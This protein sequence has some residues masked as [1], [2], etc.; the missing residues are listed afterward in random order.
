VEKNAFSAD[1]GT[2]EFIEA[3]V[4]EHINVARYRPSD[5]GARAREMAKWLRKDAAES[6]MS[7]A[8]ID[9]AIAGSIGAGH[10]LVNYISDAMA[11]VTNATAANQQASL[12]ADEDF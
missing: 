4:H 1:Q 11:A 5:D 3:W 7:D 8:D 12:L 6:G 10:G 9:G 2:M